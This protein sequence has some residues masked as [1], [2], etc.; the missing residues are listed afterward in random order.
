MVTGR[1]GDRVVT[2]PARGGKAAG[3][4]AVAR[5][6]RLATAVERSVLVATSDYADAVTHARRL[7]AAYGADRVL[8]V[9]DIDNTVLAMQGD[10]GS[11]QWFE[12]QDYLL[13]H[14]PRSKQLVADDFPGLLQ[15]QGKLFALGRMRPPQAN[16]PE[17]V[18]SVQAMGLRTLV[19]TSRGP[20]Y[21]DATER[22]LRRNGYDFASTAV[23]VGG[24]PR[25]VFRPYDPAKPRG[26]GLSKQDV[27]R[28][29]LGKPRDASYSA[30]VMMTSGQHKGAMLLVLLAK[31]KPKFDAVVFVDDH[32]RHVARVHDALTRRG[33]A[34]AAV[35]YQRED[36]NVHRFQ[37]G[38]K[39]SV[40]DQWRR[41]DKTLQAV[42]D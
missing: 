4:K 12:W 39:S 2:V 38:D 3:G 29:S 9:T 18:R 28:F 15:V 40:T 21:R 6:A 41:L 23:P 10:L 27:A 35:H 1:V 36:E 25:G 19:L 13:A 33:I 16:L 32:G 17:L 37:Y 42:F 11:D 31:A 20:Q 22:E 30:G 24:L 34:V 7:T 26:S 5:A 8:F 14:E